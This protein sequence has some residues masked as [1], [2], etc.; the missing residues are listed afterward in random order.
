MK[1]L[2]LSLILITIIF[3]AFAED[4][5]TLNNQMVFKGDVKKINGCTVTF[6]AA[7]G[8]KY[9]IPASDIYSVQFENITDKVYTS[10]LELTEY[11]PDACMKGSLDADN[12]HGKAG[13]HIALGVLF[14]PFA[15]IGAAVSNPTPQN[16][17]G[18]YMMSKN[19][20]LFSDPLYLSCYKK[21]AKGQ[22]V[23]NTAL[24]WLAWVIFAIAIGGS[25]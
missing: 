10:Y 18:T 5:L 1:K 15:I 24:G 11:D 19:K 7:D 8:E 21:K 2:C 22:N 13:L 25:A 6:K 20:E 4:V 3:S 9:Q 17:N 12:Y 23:G 16:G 14:G